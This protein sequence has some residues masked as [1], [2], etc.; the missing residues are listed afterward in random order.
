MAGAESTN[1]PAAS[2]QAGAQQMP[3]SQLTL[4]TLSI[5]TSCSR[6]PSTSGRLLHLRHAG[7]LVLP[8]QARFPILRVSG[9]VYRDAAK[10]SRVGVE[11]CSR[12]EEAD[13]DTIRRLIPVGPV[14]IHVRSWRVPPAHATVHHVP[15]SV[16]HQGPEQEVQ[17]IGGGGASEGRLR[18]GD[19]LVGLPDMNDAGAGTEGRWESVVAFVHVDTD[20][21]GGIW[22]RSAVTG[23][24]WSGGVGDIREHLNGAEAVTRIWCCRVNL[25]TSHSVPIMEDIGP[26]FNKVIAIAQSRSDGR[27]WT[28][29]EED[30]HDRYSHGKHVPDWLVIL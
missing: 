25:P 2:D 27:K 6:R 5:T 16:L 30:H 29:K 14:G 9:I 26:P 1:P 4:L 22:G 3:R 12:G 19:D 17:K 8:K 24:E 7:L 20:R 23:Y 11:L 13:S 18:R 15:R 10:I 21:S 28:V